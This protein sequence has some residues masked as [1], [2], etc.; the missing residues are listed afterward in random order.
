MQAAV[1]AAS[2]SGGLIVFCNG[3]TTRTIKILGTM[4]DLLGSNSDS[5]MSGEAQAL[6]EAFVCA[7]AERWRA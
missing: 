6:R 1:L 3:D 2:S 7:L 4:K 5:I